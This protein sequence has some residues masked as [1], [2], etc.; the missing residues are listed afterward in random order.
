MRIRNRSVAADGAYHW[1]E[2]STPS[3]VGWTSGGNHVNVIV[4]PDPPKGFPDVPLNVD[5]SAIGETTAYTANDFLHQHRYCTPP[6]IDPR[7]R[8]QP[9]VAKDDFPQSY[10]RGWTPDD[11]EELTGPGAPL[12]PPGLTKRHPAP[13]P[14]GSEQNPYVVED[15]ENARRHR[16]ARRQAA[17]EE[18]NTARRSSR[19]SGQAAQGGPRYAS[20]KAPHASSSSTRS[21]P[22]G[23]PPPPKPDT[24]PKTPER[25]KK[26]APD[27]FSPKTPSPPE[28]SCLQGTHASQHPSS[29]PLVHSSAEA[30]HRFGHRDY[31]QLVRIRL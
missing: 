27:G 10:A 9:T 30:L 3:Q 28:A 1:Q 13:A 19:A 5:V 11:F 17:A 26:T 22:N 16:E 25:Y 7:Y 21:N 31:R 15:D 20:S 24:T 14:P 6:P 12:A 18:S 2:R 8:D 23:R 29:E 4:I